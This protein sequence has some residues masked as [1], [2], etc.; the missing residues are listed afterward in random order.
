M[1]RTTIAALSDEAPERAQKFKHEDGAASEASGSDSIASSAKMLTK[2][3]RILGD[4][5][6][7][8][9]PGLYWLRV[10]GS[11]TTLLSAGLAVAITVV[12]YDAFVNYSSNVSYTND[13]SNRM[14]YTFDCIM[15][16][17][18]LMYHA[19]GWRNFTGIGYDSVEAEIQVN[20]DFAIG[21]ASL[22]LD[23]HRTMYNHILPTPL[24][25]TYTKPYISIYEYDSPGAQMS[26][27]PLN[28]NLFQSG[29][30]FATEANKAAILPLASLAD[31]WQPSLN[32]IFTNLTPAGNAHETL[33][34][35][36]EFGYALTVSS[37]K[38]VYQ[39][40]IITYVAM[41]GF[42]LIVAFVVF[43]PILCNIEAE[44]DSIVLRFVDLPKAAKT[45]LYLQSLRRLKDLRSSFVDDDDDE[46]EAGDE[47]GETVED[48][49]AGGGRRKGTRKGQD[50]QD[51][52]SDSE[53]DGALKA[54]RENAIEDGDTAAANTDWSQILASSQQSRGSVASLGS[55]AAASKAPR[56][57][58]AKVRNAAREKRR[59]ERDSVKHKV[60]YVKS[61]T[62]FLLLLSRFLGPLGALAI[63]FSI[64]FGVSIY[65]L[66][67]AF[68]LSSIAAS[69]TERSSCSREVFMD[70][71]RML[72]QY[73]DTDYMSLQAGMVS[74]TNDCIKY[75][76]EVLEYG[77][78]PGTESRGDFAAN[79]PVTET[80][81]S[82]Y[83]TSQLNADIYGALYGDLCAF[84]HRHVENFDVPRCE[85][86]DSG[87]LK[88]GLSAGVR[89]YT[90]Y[91]STLMDRRRRVLMVYNSS[92]TLAGFEVPPS[93]FNYSADFCSLNPDECS[94]AATYAD[95][96]IV[97]PLPPQ[98]DIDFNG[99]RPSDW[100]S[101][102]SAPPG[103]VPWSAA[104][105]LNGLDMDHV[106]D[107][108]SLYVTPAL[109][110]IAG[111]LTD[112][113]I[114]VVNN[115]LSFIVIFVAV[116]ISC[117]L[118]F[119]GTSY[120]PSIGTTNTD[121]Q[122][123]RAMLLYVDPD[124]V[125][126]SPQ[127]KKLVA[128]ILAAESDQYG[129]G[130]GGSASGR[131]HHRKAGASNSASDEGSAAARMSDN[132]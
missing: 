110:L 32:W 70:M 3:R 108:D 85:A 62:G 71:Q 120:L 41:M 19:R 102:P 56:S 128:S 68:V 121:I 76:M 33:H 79:T 54:M 82:P 46:G 126:N 90:N 131:G 30:R 16:I 78:P 69:A 8:L 26:G 61:H 45:T 28:V 91:F 101:S 95:I 117:F 38:A 74:D 2:L 114:T 53:E 23:V 93:A 27:V 73:A 20:R 66:D 103:T 6:Q 75:W 51:S 14:L 118:C 87:N 88:N 107:A 100:L 94:G 112:Y 86:F 15:A 98:Q 96:N 24:A 115:F 63:F 10:V 113:T 109:F 132:R 25:G 64:I 44:K 80:G 11:I 124:M 21:N 29:V 104:L 123:K 116:F 4:R 81:T 52:D 105:E 9:L 5:D 18:A 84:L 125:M 72:Q 130:P 22:F 42:L 67:T 77:V 47:D 35:S 37:Y 119:M 31:M 1:R 17:Q 57:A 39:T 97:L 43:L 65:Y 36:L 59:A 58:T 48:D 83:L 50:G 34:L 89:E 92:A 12:T 106:R 127:I 111:M 99:D 129:A 55:G 122:T 7:T 49:A 13:G 60:K 40:Q